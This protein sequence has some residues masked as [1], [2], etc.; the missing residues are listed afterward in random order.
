MK[1]LYRVTLTIE[2]LALA[3]SP[4]KAIEAVCEGLFSHCNTVSTMEQAEVWF[5]AYPEGWDEDCIPWGA[6]NDKTIAQ[7]RSEKKA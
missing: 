4:E 6:E 7:L 1:R 5:G 2:E 3:N